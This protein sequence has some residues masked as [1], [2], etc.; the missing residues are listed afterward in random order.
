MDGVRLSLDVTHRYVMFNKPAGVVTTMTDPQGRPCI[1]DHLD[2]SMKAARLV[3]VGRLD[4]ETEGLLLLTND[5]ELAHRLTHPSYEVPKTYLVE[6]R[7]KVP[8]SLGRTLTE[9]IALEDGPIA[10]DAFREIASAQ[11]RSMVEV[12]L[13]SGRNRIVRR[14]FEQVGHPVTRL[15]RTAIGEIT[16]GDQPQGTVRDLGAR[17]LGHLMDLTSAPPPSGQGT[18]KGTQDQQDSTTQ[19]APTS[20]THRGAGHRGRGGHR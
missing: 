19:Q 16:I 15:V 12:T 3:H 9:G 18:S 8:R 13:H 11:G 20:R 5:G 2:A 10:V 17:E 1:E 6:V 14:I 7:G 4:R